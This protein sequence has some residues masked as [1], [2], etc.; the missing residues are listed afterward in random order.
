MSY[1]FIHVEVYARSASKLSGLKK[2][3]KGAIRESDGNRK[4][5]SARD[6]LAEAL[7]EVGACN[8]VKTPLLPEVL[9]GDLNLLTVDLETSEPP[10]GQRKDT[11]ILLAGVASAPW[12]PGDPRS[13]KWR[14]DTIDFLKKTYVDDLDTVIGHNDE[15]HDHLHFYIKSSI[16]GPVKPLH[17]GYL[18]QSKAKAEGAS[19]KEQTRVYKAA[20]QAFQD[21]YFAAVSEKFGLARKGPG[22]QRLGRAEWLEVKNDNRARADRLQ[23][24][25]ISEAEIAQKLQEVEK[26]AQKNE[27]VIVQLRE[28]KALLEKKDEKIS[29]REGVLLEKE[30]IFKQEKSL[31][32]LERERFYKTMKSVWSRITGMEKREIEPLLS[33]DDKKEIGL[34][35]NSAPAF[36]SGL[37]APRTK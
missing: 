37:T 33:P 11:P 30:Q 31:F 23:K 22:R 9:L 29:V 21:E 25:E 28:V 15:A 16:F 4:N 12:P 17:Q 5:W 35:M 6:V 20:M 27:S 7:R 19:A 14:L 8:H 10:K 36:K 24:I 18:A 26:R 13:K 2:A 3:K 34:S 32:Q 1:Q